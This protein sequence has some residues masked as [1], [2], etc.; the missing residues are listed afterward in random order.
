MTAEQYRTAQ[1]LRQ[2][3]EREYALMSYRLPYKSK[4]EG[5]YLEEEDEEEEQPK[6]PEIEDRYKAL[7]TLIE[8]KEVDIYK[9]VHRVW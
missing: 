2:A 9:R 1:K 3:L 7:Y 8:Y 5:G 4:S 6:A